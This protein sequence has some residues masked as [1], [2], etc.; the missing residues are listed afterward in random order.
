MRPALSG[1]EGVDFVED[2]GLDGAEGFAGVGG[3]EEIER[4]GC[5]DEN[6]RR[7]AK[8]ACALGGRRVTGADGGGRLMMCDA[9]AL[10]GVADADEWRLQI[11]LD[12]DGERFDGGDIEDA[13][14]IRFGGGGRKHQAVD[15][16]EERGERFAG[17]CG[18]ENQRGIATGNGRPAEVLRTRGCGEDGFEPVA[19][20]ERKESE[21]VAGSGGGGR[22]LRLR[23]DGSWNSTE[24]DAENPKR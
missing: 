15:A 20:S 9:K 8:E 4:F 1:R 23:H 24:L 22:I 14:A 3:Q 12:V 11:A 6:V 21:G 13:A 5:S 10:R 18:S 7:M 16:P 19:R 17:A 2:Y